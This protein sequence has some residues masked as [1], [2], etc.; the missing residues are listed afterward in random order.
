MKQECLIAFAFFSVG[1][2]GGFLT[3]FAYACWNFVIRACECRETRKEVELGRLDN[4]P[5]V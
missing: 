1:F 3:G 4:L 2:S 5:K